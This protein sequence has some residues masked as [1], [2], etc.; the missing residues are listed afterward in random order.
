[1]THT[2][3]ISGSYHV[4]CD[5]GTR[6]IIWVVCLI[7]LSFCS[8]TAAAPQQDKATLYF[9][10]TSGWKVFPEKL[11]LLDNDKKIASLNRGHYV[12]LQITPGRH[13]LRLKYA[14]SKKLQVDLDATPGVTYYFAGGFYPGI[15]A[16]HAEWEFAEITKDEADKLLA[17]MKPPLRP[18]TYLSD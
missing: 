12:A 4:K 6:R 9:L 8:V 14:P 3:L 15:S 18:S 11:S 16:S 10:N 7:V 17:K 2:E 13:V 5:R 1:M